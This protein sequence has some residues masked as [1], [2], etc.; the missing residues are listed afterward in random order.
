MR[1][2]HL[3][4]YSMRVKKSMLRNFNR[5]CTR[6]HGG[7]NETLNNPLA[8]VEYFHTMISAIIGNMLKGGM[9][10]DVSRY[11][12]TIEYQGRGTPHTHLG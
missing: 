4:R 9:F 5:N 2:I 8:V 11:Y 6:W 12:A 1:G 10:G 3:W 7:Q